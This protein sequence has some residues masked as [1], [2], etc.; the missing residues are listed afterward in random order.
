MKTVSIK[1]LNKNPCK[2]FGH[3][4]KSWGKCKICGTKIYPMGYEVILKELRGLQ[5]PKT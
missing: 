2:Y 1:E 3:D 4:G 5:H